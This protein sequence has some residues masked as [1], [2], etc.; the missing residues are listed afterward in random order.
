MIEERDVED[1]AGLA[2]L[3]RLVDV[4]YARGGSSARVVVEEDDRCGVAHQRF[5][6]DPPVV[7]L[8]RLDGSDGNHL[9]GQGQVGSIEEEDPGLLMIEVPQVFAQ[10]TCGLSRCFDRGEVIV[11][12]FLIHLAAV[13][14]VKHLSLRCEKRDT[15]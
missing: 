9:L 12:R 3:V 4:S 13:L 8:G 6:D 2:E 7:D 14:R 10:V 15:L 5:L 1:V 11:V